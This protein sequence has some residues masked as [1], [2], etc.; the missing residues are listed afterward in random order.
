MNSQKPG[1]RLAQRA[2]AVLLVAFALLSSSIAVSAP[3]RGGGDVFSA[4][5]AAPAQTDAAACR[6]PQIARIEQE[7]GTQARVFDYRASGTASG[8]LGG[9]LEARGLVEHTGVCR[10]KPNALVMFI[11]NAKVAMVDDVTNDYFASS[12]GGRPPAGSNSGG[13]YGERPGYD[14]GRSTGRGDSDPELAAMRRQD[15]AA[16]VGRCGTVYQQKGNFGGFP[17]CLSDRATGYCNDNRREPACIGIIAQAQDTIPIRP[18]SAAGSSA[19]AGYNTPGGSGT[20]LQEEW[21]RTGT[22]ADRQSHRTALRIRATTNPPP[23]LQGRALRQ[24]AAARS[25]ER[26]HQRQHQTGAAKQLDYRQHKCS[27][28]G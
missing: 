13:T 3:P 21:Q 23:P 6:D 20:V 11:D 2:A 25:P 27:D 19:C 10:G 8:E 5:R 24:P 1:D 18:G 9:A 22:L 4:S 28:K 26:K 12:A 15:D 7:T 17:S 14:S 16:L